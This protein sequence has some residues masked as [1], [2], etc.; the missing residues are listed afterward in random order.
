MKPEVQELVART[1]RQAEALRQ[2]APFLTEDVA[3][4][5]AGFVDSDSILSAVKPEFLHGVFERFAV[6][7]D[8]VREVVDAITGRYSCLTR[9]DYDTL[10]QMALCFALLDPHQ[11]EVTPFDVRRAADAIAKVR[12]LAAEEGS[13]GG[14]VLPAA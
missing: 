10:M 9:D 13:D 6:T 1:R 14:Q 5:L 2:R 7:Q 12:K 3:G 4:F 11:W 8:A